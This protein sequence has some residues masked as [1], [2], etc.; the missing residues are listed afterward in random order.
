[1]TGLSHPGE[2]L[3]TQPLLV[4]VEAGI[5]LLKTLILDHNSFP[6]SVFSGMAILAA[7]ARGSA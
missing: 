1:M 7:E 6:I 4:E 3:R 2:V 5:P